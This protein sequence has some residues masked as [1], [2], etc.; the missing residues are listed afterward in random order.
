MHAEI[1]AGGADAESQLNC[2]WNYSTRRTRRRYMLWTGQ[3]STSLIALRTSDSSLSAILMRW[4]SF[5]EFPMTAKYSISRPRWN[6]QVLLSLRKYALISC[7]VTSH[8]SRDGLKSIK[9][10]Q[11]LSRN[12][13]CHNLAGW[14][15]TFQSSRIRGI[16][17]K[18]PVFIDIWRRRQSLH[19]SWCVSKNWWVSRIR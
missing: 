8:A 7:L 6:R 4:N 9:K 19:L 16:L 12:L 1:V 14:A 18:R 17:D 3:P 10:V 13:G 2:V 11:S 5:L 15:S